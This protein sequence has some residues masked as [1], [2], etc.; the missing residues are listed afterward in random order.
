[1]RARSPACRFRPV[2]AQAIWA[3]PVTGVMSSTRTGSTVDVT[4]NSGEVAA[5]RK[6]FGAAAIEYAV[7]F[8][9]RDIPALLAR[10]AKSQS[11]FRVCTT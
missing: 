8:V 5:A 6:A 7:S 10:S 2:T 1:M 11:H 4:T 9:E 3:S